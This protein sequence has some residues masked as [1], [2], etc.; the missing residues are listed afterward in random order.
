M[1]NCNSSRTDPLA[2]PDSRSLQ[3]A[4]FST[5]PSASKLARTQKEIKHDFRAFDLVARNTQV[6]AIIQYGYSLL[7]YNAVVGYELE[8]EN[9]STFTNA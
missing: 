7:I 1:N 9:Q 2:F 6:A 3:P 4:V 8:V 5:L